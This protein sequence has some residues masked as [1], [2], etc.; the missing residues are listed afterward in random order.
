M[1]K[2]ES[3]RSEPAPKSWPALAATIA[4]T[5]AGLAAQNPMV[6]RSQLP[7]PAC[8]GTARVVMA[9]FDSSGQLDFVYTQISPTPALAMAHDPVTSP[10]GG[11]C[12]LTPAP[13]APLSTNVPP[14]L[15]N[16][17]GDAFPDVLIDLGVGAGILDAF[18]DG[19]GGFVIPGTGP[20]P[21][22]PPVGSLTHRLA[23]DFNHDGRHDVAAANGPH[24]EV[25]LNLLSGWTLASS[26][27]A[28]STPF[29][30]GAGDFD[31][32]GNVDL[33][34]AEGPAAA[35]TWNLRIAYGSGSGTFALAVAPLFVDSVIQLVE[36]VKD[37]DGDGKDDLLTRRTDLAFTGYDLPIVWGA[38]P[39][40]APMVTFISTTYETLDRPRAI[41]FDADGILDIVVEASPLW[42]ATARDLLL[43]RGLGGRQ[44]S[45]PIVLGTEPQVLGAT[46]NLYF[47]D[48]DGDQDVDILRTGVSSIGYQL[49]LYRNETIRAPGCAGTGGLVPSCSIGLA[50]PGNPAFAIGLSSAL[51]NSFAALGVSLA[52]VAVSGCGLAIDVSQ[53]ILPMGSVGIMGTNASGAASMALPL[54]PPPA[55]NGMAF[56]VQWGVLDPQ[57]S[58]PAT[59]LTFALSD[60][61][62]VYVW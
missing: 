6:T 18:G 17:N 12:Q 48:V 19:N 1:T 40:V 15:A 3:P 13:A 10:G 38:A 43:Y 39:P 26:L 30:I 11:T 7:T 53:L 20:Y 34:W 54:P 49:L 44:F 5:A 45:A 51:P 31:G 36:D 61:R 25:S 32:D 47:A 9:D 55:L 28:P 33:F 8:T 56:H 57:G 22:Q 2:I 23:R 35:V 62:T 59:G 21:L 52:P 27:S 29:T 41:D 46:T 24:V 50:T 37:L 16:L 4:L 58:L 42:P 60:A 14:L